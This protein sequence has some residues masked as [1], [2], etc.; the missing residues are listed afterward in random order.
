M[1]IS[2]QIHAAHVFTPGRIQENTP[3]ELFMYWFRARGQAGDLHLISVHGLS[4]SSGAAK[5]QG[6][7]ER[8]PDHADQAECC[9]KLHRALEGRHV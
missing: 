7:R 4:I 9:S 8:G 5:Q 2:V 6:S 1:V 3:G